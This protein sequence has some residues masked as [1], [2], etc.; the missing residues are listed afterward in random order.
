MHIDLTPSSRPSKPTKKK[1]KNRKKQKEWKEKEEDPK[2]NAHR[3]HFTL[4]KNKI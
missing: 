3:I 4:K 2:P 1:P